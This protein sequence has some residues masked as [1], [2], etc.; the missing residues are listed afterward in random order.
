MEYT[1][2]S[3]MVSRRVLQGTAIPGEIVFNIPD[4]GGGG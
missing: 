3:A 2:L 1:C 4:C